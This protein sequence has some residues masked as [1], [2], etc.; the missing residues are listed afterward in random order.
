MSESE[1]DFERTMIIPP[2]GARGAANTPPTF[3]AKDDGV[4]RMGD[5]VVMQPSKRPPAADAGKSAPKVDF[6][7]THGGK[8]PA[9][10]VAKPAGATGAPAKAGGHGLYLIIAVVVAAALGY[11]LLT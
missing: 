7:V 10:G 1:E 11:V 3:G 4:D 8:I 9:P 2:P 5:T 6:D